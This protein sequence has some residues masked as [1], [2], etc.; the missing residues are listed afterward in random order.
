[1][2]NRIREEPAVVS[3]FVAALLALGVSF[4]LNLTPQQVGAIV[5]VVAAA[6][7]FVVRSKVTP[8]SK[9]PARE[10]ARR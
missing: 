5:A 9:D 3:G 8:T 7:A 10:G 4:G 2:I 6:L 1:M